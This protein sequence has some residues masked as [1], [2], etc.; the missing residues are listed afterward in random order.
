MNYIISEQLR[1]ALISYLETKPFK[2]VVEGVIAL[3][4]LPPIPDPK[5]EPQVQ[6]KVKEV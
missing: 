1:Q 5:V 4:N 6:E 2:E 3:R